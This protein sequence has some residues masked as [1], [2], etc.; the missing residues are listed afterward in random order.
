MII[1]YIISARTVDFA[2]AH[3]G[4]CILYRQRERQRQRERERERE[5][6]KDRHEHA[7]AHAKYMMNVWTSFVYVT[8]DGQGLCV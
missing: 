5:R 1:M 3:L 6:E 2:G 7:H 8:V 4:A